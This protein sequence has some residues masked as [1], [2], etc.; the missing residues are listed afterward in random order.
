VISMIPL[1]LIFFVFQKYVI[2]AD[3]NAG[4]KD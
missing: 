4:L 3:V 2:G 1:V